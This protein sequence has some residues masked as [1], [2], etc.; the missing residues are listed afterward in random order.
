MIPRSY[1]LWLKSLAMPLAYPEID[2]RACSQADSRV[3]K[4]FRFSRET[5]CCTY[6]PFLPN[7][8]LGA[9]LADEASAGRVQRALEKGRA[10]PLG[11]F[12]TPD[13]EARRIEKG[14]AGF[15]R[16]PDLL[17][18]MFEAG[19]CTIWNHR[20]GVCASYFCR[21]AHALGPESKSDR[22][23]SWR[24]IEAYLG[25]FEWTLAHEVLWRCGFTQ[26]EI[27]KMEESRRSPRF[28]AKAAWLEFVGR[29]EEFYR[30]AAVEAR[31]VG[32]D[33]V[34][35]LMGKEGV[36]LRAAIL[37]VAPAVEL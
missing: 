16:S 15:G 33:E 14:E 29:E 19:G 37:S 22:P 31:G 7:F 23:N 18:P 28:E 12:A 26:D 34:E 13:F 1:E 17:C 10:T 4:E 2:C 24:D 9:L 35:R 25:L 36:R 8:T 21:S 27:R 3:P 5:K 6:F 32:T 30:R 20:P 11:L